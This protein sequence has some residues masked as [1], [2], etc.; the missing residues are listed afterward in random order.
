MDEVVS[1]EKLSWAKQMKRRGLYYEG[2]V[3]CDDNRRSTITSYDTRTSSRLI[4]KPTT[5]ENAQSTEGNGTVNKTVIQN[6]VQS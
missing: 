1:N 6:K 5:S 4:T 3:D 2:L